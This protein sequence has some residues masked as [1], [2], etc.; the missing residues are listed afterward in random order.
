MILDVNKG[1]V[2]VQEFAQEENELAHAE[3]ARAEQETK[4]DLRF[5]AVLVKADSL[6]RLRE[7]YP[8]YYLNIAL[9]YEATRVLMKA[10]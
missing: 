2:H 4:D 10:T 9:F 5:D 3:Y 1:R 8:N 7:A 6:Q